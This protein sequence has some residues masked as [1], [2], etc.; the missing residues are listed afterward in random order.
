MTTRYSLIVL[1]AIS[2]VANSRAESISRTVVDGKT[3]AIST[4]GYAHYYTEYLRGHIAASNTAKRLWGAHDI[5]NEII[6]YAKHFSDGKLD[7]VLRLNFYV[8]H[9]RG[10]NADPRVLRLGPRV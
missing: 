4:E 6:F 9:V 3:V 10:D 1:L 2:L 7:G 5:L 8:G